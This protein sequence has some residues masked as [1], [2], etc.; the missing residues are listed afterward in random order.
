MYALELP[1]GPGRDV[2]HCPS[3]IAGGQ[4]RYDTGQRTGWCGIE[5]QDA[6]VRVRTALEEAGAERPL[7]FVTTGRPRVE[8]LTAWG[9]RIVLWPG[10]E[11]EFLG[12]A[13]YHGAWLDWA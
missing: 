6:R 4:H 10:G 12:H 7:A 3:D 9:L 2:T 8:R 13:D 5:G 11:R 1:C